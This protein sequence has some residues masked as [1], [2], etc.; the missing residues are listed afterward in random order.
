M[1]VCHVRQSIRSSLLA[2]LCAGICQAAAAQAAAGRADSTRGDSLKRVARSGLIPP[3][4]GTLRQDDVA[5]QVQNLGLLVKLVPLEE[6][7]IRTLAPDSYRALHT[8][9]ENKA[10]QLDSIRTRLGLPGVQAWLVEFFNAQQGDARYDVMDI[11]IRSSGRDFRPLD[12]L[13]VKPG[14]GDGRLAQRES[15]SA[16]Y[17]F[18]PAIDL[19]QPITVTIGTQTSS[20]WND[21]AQRIE[22]E[23]SFVWSRAGAAKP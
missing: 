3:G 9:R 12:V 11:L 10:R 22:L 14:F 1:N 2:L 20:A 23:R 21:I 18:D 13:P 19:T 17:A 4:F 5:I 6:S 15:R 7:V 16:V 8:I